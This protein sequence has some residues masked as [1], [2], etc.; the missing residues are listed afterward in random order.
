MLEYYKFDFKKYI[1]STSERWN[2]KIMTRIGHFMFTEYNE[3][4]Y[5]IETKN[6]PTA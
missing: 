3:N 5:F 1:L 2:K 6:K 4:T